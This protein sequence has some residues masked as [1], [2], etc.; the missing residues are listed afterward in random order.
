[1]RNIILED[2]QRFVKTNSD[3]VWTVVT[4]AGGSV[5][6]FSLLIMSPMLL[7]HILKSS[8]FHQQMES[9]Q[10]VVASY[11][12]CASKITDSSLIRDYCGDKPES[13]PGFTW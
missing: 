6:T 11:Q 10:K 3:E 1:M 7:N 2:F 4:V 9:Y 8:Q 5:I 12:N 13:P